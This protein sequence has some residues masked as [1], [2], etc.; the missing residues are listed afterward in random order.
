[1]RSM[2]VWALSSTT[3][4]HY[5]VSSFADFQSPL[6]PYSTCF[7]RFTNFRFWS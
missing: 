2:M 5:H 4:E 7:S 6:P 3:I 1:M